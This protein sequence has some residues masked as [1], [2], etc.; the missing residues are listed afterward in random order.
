VT[1]TSSTG[2][3]PL[4]RLP[5]GRH[6]LPPELV[7]ESQRQRL[8]IAA[9]ESLAEHGYGEITTTGIAKRA[10]VST[11]TLYKN[12]D[13][14]WACLLAAYEAATQRLCEQI[15]GACVAIPDGERRRRA[16][17]GIAAALALLAAEPALAHLL[18]AE[19][20]SQVAALWSARLRLT[21]RLSILL[22][23]AR[24]PFGSSEREARLVGGALALVSIRTRIKGT[25]HLED[26][27]PGLTGILLG[28]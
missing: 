4:E 23:S 14:L 26:L 19:P 13:D 16:E 21:A 17:A 3:P 15:E 18:S 7:R 1:E 5:P 20:P 10:G 24:E 8:M 6:G 9:A 27:G 12:F 11:S 28:R 25:D 2:S 22:H